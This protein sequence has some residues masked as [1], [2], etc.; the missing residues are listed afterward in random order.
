MDQCL[1]AFLFVHFQCCE[2]LQG[3]CR[4]S[5]HTK[6][7]KKPEVLHQSRLFPESDKEEYTVAACFCSHLSRWQQPV[8]WCVCFVHSLRL[9]HIKVDGHC[10]LWDLVAIFQR[11]SKCFSRIVNGEFLICQLMALTLFWGHAANQCNRSQ[12][13]CQEDEMWARQHPSW[14]V[15]T[16]WLP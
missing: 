9:R 12:T 3:C 6:A 11:W 13:S 1:P 2:E 10:V 5:L 14:G 8:I 7:T 15:R 4:A 16:P